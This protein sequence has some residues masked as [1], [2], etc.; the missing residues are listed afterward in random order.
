MNAHRPKVSIITPS[1]NQGSFIRATI[2]SVPAQTYANI[3][4]VLVDGGL[5]DDT[6]AVVDEYRRRID[7]TIH[8][9]YS[10]VKQLT[11]CTGPAS[12]PHESFSH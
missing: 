7:V 9:A 10:P 3:E 4:Y 11:D 2:E 8:H 5:T 1:F 6:M 12:L